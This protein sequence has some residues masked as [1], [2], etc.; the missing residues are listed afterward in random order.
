MHVRLLSVFIP[1]VRPSPMKRRYEAEPYTPLGQCVSRDVCAYKWESY[2]EQLCRTKPSSDGAFKVLA[3]YLI[4]A[5]KHNWE[6][7]AKLIENVYPLRFFKGF[8]NTNFH[9]I[10]ALCD[11]HSETWR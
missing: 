8:E 7:F 4:C 3:I 11:F 9:V 6:I 1:E 10:P 2:H 5:G